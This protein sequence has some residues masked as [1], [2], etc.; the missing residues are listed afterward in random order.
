MKFSQ[1]ISDSVFS[2]EKGLVVILIPAML[3]AMVFDIFFRYFLNSPLVWAQ[4]IALYT[5]VWSSFLGASMS[6][7]VKEAVAVTLFIDKMPSKIRNV[8]ILVGLIASTIFAIYIFYLS[9]TWIMDPS[10]L[11]QKTITTQIPIVYMYLSIP[12]SLLFMSVHF[13][14]W[15]IEAI[16]ISK[17]G[18][19][20]T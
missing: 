3:L 10:I 1:T 11:L 17:D 16:R 15:F 7:K 6:I 5:F 8:L 12:I 18:K 13:I 9:I 4:E 2:L 14:H 20:I 19:V